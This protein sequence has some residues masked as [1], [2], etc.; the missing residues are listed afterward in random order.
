MLISHFLPLITFHQSLF[1]H[2]HQFIPLLPFPPLRI[3]CIHSSY[4]FHTRS[5]IH[6]FIH[7]SFHPFI[8]SS[9]IHPFTPL[10]ISQY[11]FIF[12]SLY[13]F[14]SI[15]LSF[16]SS[17]Y[18]LSILPSISHSSIHLSI[19]LSIPHPFNHSFI[20][21]HPHNLLK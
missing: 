11:P 18:P 5:S 7:F 10:Y 12:Q 20:L 1:H 6:P 16:R 17:N 21:Y 8:Y 4:H 3:E 14:P 19:L 9:S 13:L 15:H 2:L